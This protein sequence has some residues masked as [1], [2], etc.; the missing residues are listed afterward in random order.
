MKPTK[1]VKMKPFGTLKVRDAKKGATVPVRSTTLR[2]PKPK[3]VKPVTG[4]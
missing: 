3:L 2:A 4:E 1:V